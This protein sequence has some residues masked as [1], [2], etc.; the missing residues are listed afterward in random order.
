M[1]RRNRGESIE[2][3]AERTGRDPEQIRRVI[4]IATGLDDPEGD[5]VNEKDERDGTEQSGSDDPA[6]TGYEYQIR[7]PEC[8]YG[9]DCGKREFPVECGE[10]M[11][12]DVGCGRL[13]DVQVVVVDDG[14]SAG[15]EA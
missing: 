5:E 8:G 12:D 13:L 1:T 10:W 6:V 7:C 15:D 9:I 11:P 4:R 2:E 14:D 3:Q